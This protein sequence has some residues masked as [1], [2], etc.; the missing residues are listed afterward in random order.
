MAKPHFWSPPWSQSP[1][2][3]LPRVHPRDALGHMRRSPRPPSSLP[4]RPQTVTSREPHLIAASRTHQ[5]DPDTA[6]PSG[7]SAVPLLV[8]PNHET[9]EGSPLT[10]TAPR[11][12]QCS[13]VRGEA[14]FSCSLSGVL[15]YKS[16]SFLGDA[17]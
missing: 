17:C 9:M 16:P 10:V 13:S 8:G 2:T 14:V 15:G 11:S 1:P 4:L 3:F 6:G 7:F 5:A 12:L